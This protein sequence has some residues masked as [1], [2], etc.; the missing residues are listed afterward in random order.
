MSHKAT[1]TNN[2]FD[3][4][5]KRIVFKTTQIPYVN[6]NNNSPE[7]IGSNFVNQTNRRFP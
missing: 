5:Q 3:T 6:D 2:S 1:K 4:R 7:Y